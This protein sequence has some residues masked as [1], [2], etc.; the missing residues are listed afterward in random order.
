MTAHL[1]HGAAMVLLGLVAAAIGS[2]AGLGGGFVVA[3][4][5]RLFFH[6]TPSAAAGT[7]LVLVLANVAS[8][9]VAF[10]RQGRVDVRLGVTMGLLA[11]PGSIGG[12]LLVRLAPGTWFDLSYAGLLVIFAVDL[13]RRPA[14][15]AEGGTATLPWARERIFHDRI[16]G[17]E[18]RYAESPPIAAGAGLATG[19]L[20]SFFGIGGGV[21]VV[22]L[23][24]RLFAMPAHI[25]SATSHTVILFSAPFGVATHALTGSIDWSD[26]LPLAL[27]GLAGGQLGAKASRYLSGPRLVR[28]VAIVLTVAAASLIGEHIAEIPAFSGTHTP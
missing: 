14:V 11:I 5:L 27:G 25:V 24:L 7:S 20:S 28:I 18:Y 21:L 13:W 22:P 4:A 17:T 6:L 16:S 19:F 8:A 9:S 12:A 26:A 2:L 1:L 10:Y 3:P 23:M 15:H